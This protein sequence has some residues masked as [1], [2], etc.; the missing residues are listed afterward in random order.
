[1]GLYD[2][3]TGQGSVLSITGNGSTPSTNP[4]STKASKLHA[5]GAS[6]GYSLAGANASLVN[7]QYQQYIDGVPNQL[8]Q[9]SQLDLN[10]VTPPKYLDNPPR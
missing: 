7:T 8:P 9:P 6:A 3:L 4:L 10:G 5:D 2:K 1:M